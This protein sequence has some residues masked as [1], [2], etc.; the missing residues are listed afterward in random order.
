MPR[1]VD[2]RAGPWIGSV[3]LHAIVIALIA[4]AAFTWRSDA[5]QPPLAIEGSVVRYEDLPSAV[6]A[7]K[8]LR[9]PKPPQPEPQ[10]QPQP[11][12]QPEP[13]VPPV[14]EPKPKPEP[15]PRQP[16][17]PAPDDTA[18]KAAEARAEAQAQARAEAAAKQ[19]AD[20]QRAAAERR[21][22]ETEK[23]EQEAAAAREQK[24]RDEQAARDAKHKAEREAELR[25]ALASEEEGEAIAQSGVVDEYR[26]LLVQA[27]ERNWVRPPSARAGLE[28]ALNVTQAPGGVVMDVKIG[29]CNGDEAVRESV[30]NAVFRASPLPPPRDPRAFERRL[31]IVFKPKE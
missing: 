31:V 21:Q 13:A 12:P 1:F 17:T 24:A 27:I 14:P 6:K 10:P 9:E 11:E 25:R 26:A 22:A 5:P 2:G 20:E 30:K 7:G 19:K 3:A 4:G 16:P 18:A 23:R 29:E 8:P 15:E 28:C